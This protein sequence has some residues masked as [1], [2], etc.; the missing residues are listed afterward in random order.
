M[1]K[2]EAEKFARVAGRVRTMLLWVVIVMLVVTAA[3]VGVSVL[4]GDSLAQFTDRL[5][6]YQQ[7]IEDK[8]EGI[9]GVIR[10]LE[11]KLDSLSAKG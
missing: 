1:V 8:A 2:G 6:A 5:P 7:P 10:K 3:L 9:D 4:A 11:S